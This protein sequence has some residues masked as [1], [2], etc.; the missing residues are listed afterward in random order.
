MADEIEEI[1]YGI[2]V[3]WDDFKQGIGVATQAVHKFF[4]DLSD[5]MMKDGKSA[6]EILARIK[7]HL[8]NFRDNGALLGKMGIDTN[9]MSPEAFEKFFKQSNAAYDRELGQQYKRYYKG[10]FNPKPP[11]GNPQV[12]DFKKAWDEAAM[13][14]VRYKASLYALERPFKMVAG[15][16]EHLRQA[17]L[18]FS[19]LSQK[20]LTTASNLVGGGGAFA[21]LGGSVASYANFRNS[22]AMEMEKRRIGLGNGGQFTQALM[23]YGI[24]YDP[25]NFDRTMQNIVSFMSSGSKSDSQK[26]MAGRMLGMDDA[27]I[28]AAKRGNAFYNDYQRTIK[29]M[30]THQDEAAEKAQE[31]SLETYKLNT[32]FTD[33]K[34]AIFRDIQPFIK[35]ITIGLTKITELINTGWVRAIAEIVAGITGLLVVKGLATIWIRSFMAM[36]GPIGKMIPLLIRLPALIKGIFAAKAATETASTISSIAKGGSKISQ[37]AGTLTKAGGSLGKS[38]GSFAGGGL[39]AVLGAVTGLVQVFQTKLVV[40]SL[41]DIIRIIARWQ[42]MWMEK[43]KSDV[44]LFNRE[45][46]EVEMRKLDIGGEFLDALERN[47]LVS[48]AQER[49]LVRSDA[50]YKQAMNNGSGGNSITVEH[51]AVTVQTQAADPQ[52]VADTVHEV[53]VNEFKVIEYDKKGVGI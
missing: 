36:L 7:S 12:D 19:L 51:L 45:Q 30:S 13:S 27:M 26:L 15:F 35:W 17:N 10:E 47:Q 53:L 28:A 31:L 40:D 44:G 24:N 20:A 21:A 43:F 41:Q 50:Y 32:A 5:A 23:H 49:A 42:V 38:A 14:V 4:A 34:N 8:V 37:T 2:K 6:D 46:D 39:G 11:T 3:N 48:R 52:A 9:A 29:S 16:T 25:R 1:E 18:Q 33:L 22:F